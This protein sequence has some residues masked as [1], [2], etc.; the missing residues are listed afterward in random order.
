M[1]SS[2]TAYVFDQHAAHERVFY[3]RFMEAYRNGSHVPQ[4]VLTP[5]TV[6]VSA[7]VYNMERDWMQTVAGMGYDIEDF[8]G[9]SFV[10]R[11]IP[12]YMSP[13]EADLFIRGLLEALDDPD[14]RGDAVEDKLIMRS[15]KSAVK[16]GEKL[17]EKE[18]EDLM[19]SLSQCANPYSCPH[20]RPTFIKLTKNDIERT[21]RR[22]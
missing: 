18:I 20:G 21:F 19:S 8:G 15:C 1:Q 12:A 9:N 6:N 5:F 2:D 3:E 4:P 14:I 11:G 10:V 17:S 16:G 7:D 13:G 22:T